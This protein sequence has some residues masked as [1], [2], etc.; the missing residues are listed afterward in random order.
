MTRFT[1]VDVYDPRE[2]DERSH[3]SRRLPGSNACHTYQLRD[4]TRLRAAPS[5]VLS[6]YTARSVN[7]LQLSH[8]GERFGVEVGIAGGGMGAY[9]FSLIGAGRIAL[10][11]PERHETFEIG[12]GQGLVHGG[13]PGMKMLTADGT[14]RTNLWIGS[15]VFETALGA[16]LGDSSRDPLVFEPVLDWATGVGASLRRLLQHV[17]EELARPDGLAENRVA[18]VAFTD[19]FVHSALRGLPHSHSHRLVTGSRSPAPLHLR[20]AEEYFLAHADRPVR[21]E[22]AAAVAGCSV[23]TLQRAF[24]RFRGTTAHTALRAARLTRARADLMNDGATIGM[25]A[26]QYGFTHSSRFA[27]AYARQFGGETPLNTVQRR[28]GV[29]VKTEAE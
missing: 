6:R 4:R 25:V 29:L 2:L 17:D 27:A 12:P 8:A 9:C 13:Q 18:L 7:A 1:V 14:I 5:K 16:S 28:S 21:L 23:R 10:S 19:L 24:L 11:V 22:D 20:R 15:H 3:V 26:R